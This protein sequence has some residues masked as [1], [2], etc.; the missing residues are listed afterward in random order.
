MDTV[1]ERKA[2]P[3][4]Y[5][6]VT[7]SLCRECDRLIPAKILEQDGLYST[8][9]TRLLKVEQKYTNYQFFSVRTAE[10]I[11]GFLNDR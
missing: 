11:I 3:Y 1:K 10:E 8:K 7:Q 6:G 2:A 5:H 4:L 9:T